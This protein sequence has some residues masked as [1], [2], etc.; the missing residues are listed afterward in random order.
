MEGDSRRFSKLHFFNT[1]IQG[2]PERLRGTLWRILLDIDRTK[3]EQEGKYE[4]M[5]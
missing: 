5:K 3:Q 4:E 1:N 2:V